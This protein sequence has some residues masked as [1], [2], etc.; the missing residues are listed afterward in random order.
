MCTHKRGPK[1]RDERN[2]SAVIGGRQEAHEVAPAV[3]YRATARAAWYGAID[4]KARSWEAVVAPK[5]VAVD[6]ST[7]LELRGHPNVHIA[8]Y[9]CG[10]VAHSR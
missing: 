9:C 8:R 3:E 4:S 7:G 1:V 2:F 5:G 10:A 6:D